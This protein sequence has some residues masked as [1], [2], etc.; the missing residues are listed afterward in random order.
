MIVLIS[1]AFL[2]GIITVLSPCILPV[3]P[4]ILT[5][6]FGKTKARPVGII[7]GFIISFA[8]F[9]LSLSWIVSSLGISPD[10]L[11]SFAVIMIISL[12]TI[13]FIPDFKII[14]QRILSKVG[15][16]KIKNTSNTNNQGF[17][18]GI[19]TGLSIGL[20]WTPCA[21][22][23]MA[24]VI[25]LAL[26]NSVDGSAV[27]ITIAYTVGTSIPM[28]AIMIGGRGLLN[29]TPWLA[30][31]TEKIQRA[32]G[33]LM[34]IVGISIAFG[35]EK[36]FQAAVLRA[37]P[38]YGNTLTTIEENETVKNALEKRKNQIK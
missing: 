6:S 18:S 31:N 12:G 38:G 25:S 35:F 19:L 21:G 10:I 30:A 34:I 5:G 27:L 29:K 11:R 24:S 9:T 32:F 17:I 1:F 13:L 22:P 23:I 26:S 15:N 16:V 20:I 4:I 8:F 33:I 37:F 2:S 36:R 7:L 3:L 14:F 28:F